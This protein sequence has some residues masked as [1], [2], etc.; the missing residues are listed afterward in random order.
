MRRRLGISALLGCCVIGLAVVGQAGASPI[1]PVTVPE[2]PLLGPADAGGSADGGAT[3][4]DDSAGTSQGVETGSID[5]APPPEDY[6]SQ[7]AWQ[8]AYCAWRDGESG[9]E[10]SLEDNGNGQTLRIVDTGGA[11]LMNPSNPSYRDDSSADIWV[12]AYRPQAAPAD[13]P[14]PWFMVSDGAHAKLGPL[15]GSGC[16]REEPQPDSNSRMLRDWEVV[17]CPR[18]GVNR[19]VVDMGD[20]ADAASG[21]VEYK[22]GSPVDAG[23]PPY[24]GEVNGGPGNDFVGDLPGPTVLDGGPGEN[25]ASFSAWVQ[26]VSRPDS[27]STVSL[28]DVA[29]DGIRDNP[30]DN[31]INVQDLYDTVGPDTLTGND[32]PNRIYSYSND[33]VYGLGG[34]DVLRALG[35]ATVDAGSGDDEII[36][37][38]DKNDPY[39]RSAPAAHI[40]CGPGYDSVTYKTGDVIADDC[41]YAYNND[42]GTWQSKSQPG[43]SPVPSDPVNSPPSVWVGAQGHFSTR[44]ASGRIQLRCDGVAAPRCVGSVSVSLAGGRGMARAASARGSSLGRASFDTAKSQTQG[45]KVPFSARAR[46]L[47]ASKRSVRAQV[48]IELANGRGGVTTV[49]RAVILRRSR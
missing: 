11:V 38:A 17:F 10:V 25:A 28:D 35:G 26:D 3:S 24:T 48:R 12:T 2:V 44:F 39:E 40:T 47:L 7:G 31:V 19:V 49:T 41:E 27:G 18:S 15:A 1:D 9:M 14:G 8:Q 30:Q 20:D 6:C 33:I 4:G 37:A 42:T 34:D 5:S 21:G 36:T 43:G 22:D 29:N 16:W 13:D 45:V 46:K 23:L 32:G